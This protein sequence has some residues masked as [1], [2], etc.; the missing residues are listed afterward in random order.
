MEKT[1]IATHTAEIKNAEYSD[2][3]TKQQISR[4]ANDRA[5]LMKQDVFWRIHGLFL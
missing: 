3:I 4:S 2:R 1:G 5:S